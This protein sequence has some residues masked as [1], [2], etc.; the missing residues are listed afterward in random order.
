V[1]TKV[2]CPTGGTS[3]KL[4]LGCSKCRGSDKAW[5]AN[6]TIQQLHKFSHRSDWQSVTA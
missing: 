2:K 5:G 1:P 4:L 3:P 6:I